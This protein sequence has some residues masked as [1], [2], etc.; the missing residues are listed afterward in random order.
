M[1]RIYNQ[2]QSHRLQS[3]VRPA[4]VNGD[5]VVGL[6]NNLHIVHYHCGGCHCEYLVHQVTDQHTFV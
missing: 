3:I 4:L 5:G 1:S 6:G 2:S